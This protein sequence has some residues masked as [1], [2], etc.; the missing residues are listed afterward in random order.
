MK[1][2]SINYI[3]LI[4]EDSPTLLNTELIQFQP[5]PISSPILPLLSNNINIK[6]NH[7]TAL[8]P[9]QQKQKHNTP[10]KKSQLNN[11]SSIKP[12]KITNDISYFK[13]YAQFAAA[14]ADLAFKTVHQHQF[15]T[16][17]SSMSNINNNHQH[18]LSSQLVD[19]TQFNLL[20]NSNTSN[21][22]TSGS[23]S[24]NLLQPSSISFANN[25]TNF[26]N[27]MQHQHQ[28]NN[29]NSNSAINLTTNL[30]YRS[31]KI[32]YLIFWV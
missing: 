24:S 18:L 14:A 22:I 21:K 6:N 12:D 17:N 15:Q 32:L 10:A 4:N 9:N 5:E 19:L 7:K 23:L 20:V 29:I 1:R 8:E 11:H 2:L 3:I 16:N 27:S 28:I 26:L 30:N 13:N 31:K 25:Y